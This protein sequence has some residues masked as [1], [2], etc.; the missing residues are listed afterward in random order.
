MQPDE[1]LAARDR[2]IERQTRA[3]GLGSRIP[4]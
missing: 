2:L 3:L 1:S 4:E